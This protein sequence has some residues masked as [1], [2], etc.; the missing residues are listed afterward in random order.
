VNEVIGDEL[1]FGASEMIVKDDH[2]VGA[3]KT[4]EFANLIEY[5]KFSNRR[6]AYIY[7]NVP[8]DASDAIYIRNIMWSAQ[9]QDYS[10][11]VTMALDV[12]S[13]IGSLY[14]PLLFVG[15]LFSFLFIDPFR[16][17]DQ[18]KSFSELK[19][20]IFIQENLLSKKEEEEK[21]NV[22]EPLGDKIDAMG[23]SFRYFWWAYKRMPLFIVD[24]V[25]NRKK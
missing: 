23:D 21:N 16:N 20:D 5:A 9:V 10:R 13:E 11:E 12:I 19:E 8:I 17:L 18:A 22:L 15:L 4:Q 7:D 25:W 3:T 14:Y 1:F 6:T 2:W 24:C